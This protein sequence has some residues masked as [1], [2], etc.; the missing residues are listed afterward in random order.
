MKERGVLLGRP[1]AKTIF[2][3]VG[4]AGTK[5]IAT[6]VVI[7]AENRFFDGSY[8]SFPGANG[9]SQVTQAGAR[10]SIATAP[11]SRNLPRCRAGSRLK[12]S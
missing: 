1:A 9:L 7:C 10:S 11:C 6:I 12:G 2:G 5:D 8:G 4:C 3:G